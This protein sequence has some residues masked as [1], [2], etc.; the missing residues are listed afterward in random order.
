MPRVNRA[1]RPV[2]PFED[3]VIRQI[4]S[5]HHADLP[6]GLA[7]EFW[8]GQNQRLNYLERI[9]DLFDTRA[10]VELASDAF[11]TIRLSLMLVADAVER[12]T[13]LTVAQ[14][15]IID[16][17]MHAAL[18]TMREKLIDALE[19]SRGSSRSKAFTQSEKLPDNA[20]EL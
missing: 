7:K 5:M 12:E 8:Y 16:R 3:E 20:G 1:D 4:L 10:V 6:K 11:K 17:L 19:Y 18:E 15:E 13:G 9:G 2:V 14:R